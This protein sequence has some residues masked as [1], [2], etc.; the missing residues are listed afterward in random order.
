M[1]IESVVWENVPK[2]VRQSVEPI[3]TE[4]IDL[5]PLWVYDFRI[6]FEA[7]SKQLA[8]MGVSHSNRWAHLVVTGNWL[9]E[10][11]IEQVVAIIHELIHIS[12]EPLWRPCQDVAR[13]IEKDVGS[14][15]AMT[16][17]RNGMEC[18][19]EDLARGILRM[20]DNKK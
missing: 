11:R 14:D 4:W 19:V 10:P 16:M 9:M 12:M 7:D 18:V 13:I 17:L 15:L 20:M 3:I 5:V 1:K 2:E 6:M 8:K